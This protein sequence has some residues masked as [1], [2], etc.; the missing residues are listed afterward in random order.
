MPQGN[1]F[2]FSSMDERHPRTA[3]GWNADYYFLMEVDGRQRH[4]SAGMTLDELTDF[5]ADLG[6]ENLMNLDGGGSATLWYLGK[7]RNSPCDGHE[8][9]IAN[10]LVVV[11]KDE[12]ETAKAPEAN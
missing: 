1:S 7:V 8:R 5:M 4:L 6:C 2:E 10:S 3:I 12:S 9:E 11:R